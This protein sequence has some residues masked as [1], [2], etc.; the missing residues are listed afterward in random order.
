MAYIL[1]YQGLV[2]MYRCV[3]AWMYVCVFSIYNY[4]IRSLYLYAVVSDYINIIKTTFD[5]YIDFKKDL[6]S[7]DTHKHGNKVKLLI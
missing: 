2:Q 6:N 1:Y 4:I 7:I 5:F 3:G